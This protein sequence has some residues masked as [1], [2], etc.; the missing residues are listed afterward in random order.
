MSRVRMQILR[1]SPIEAQEN[2]DALMEEPIDL[3]QKVQNR[4]VA[5]TRRI[6]LL[7]QKDQ[8]R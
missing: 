4:W 8:N 3:E 5:L 2:Q 6:L 7:S 1:P